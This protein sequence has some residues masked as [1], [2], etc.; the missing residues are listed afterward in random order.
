L[1][2]LMSGGLARA[3]RS[4]TEPRLQVSRL[5][6][7]IEVETPGRK[8]SVAG[9][10]LPFLRSGSIVRVRSGA[11]T[12][13][14]DARAAV[15]AGQGDAFHFTA[16]PSADGGAARVAAVETDPRSLEV[17]VGGEKF[18]LLSKGASVLLTPSAPGEVTVKSEAGDV[19][20]VAGGPAWGGKP[21]AAAHPMRAGETLIVAV[22]GDPGPDEG[23][24]LNPAGLSV[25]RKNATT[26]T[27][28]SDGTT[29]TAAAASEDSARR[30]IADW[31]EPSRLA[32]E[33]MIAKYGPPNGSD[34]ER[35]S[36][37]DSG[38]WRRTI[39]TR[40]PRTVGGV[41]EQSVGYA[42]PRAKIDDLTRMDLALDVNAS[43]DEIT[44]TSASEES[45]F[46]AVNLADE[47][48]RGV[49]TPEGARDFY[50]K[51]MRLAEAGKTSPYMQGVQFKPWGV[52]EP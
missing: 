50:R 40:H 49:R 22:G 24:R 39:V 51:T 1:S 5:S 45:N 16:V 25:S 35:L 47:V 42:V 52:T 29:E 44:S 38:V 12:F 11:A 36:W 31:P 19:A 27:A 33:A 2:A 20:I 26:F 13:R 48:L 6:G 15:R 21:G 43:A 14:S 34:D 37:N 9:Q 23:P 10:N 4:E 30:A 8:E 41:L 7:T 28:A 46:L 32:A 18:M 17:A 3:E